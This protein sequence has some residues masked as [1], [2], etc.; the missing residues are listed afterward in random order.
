LAGRKNA[1]QHSASQGRHDVIKALELARL[2]GIAAT[3]DDG[4]LADN[5]DVRPFKNFDHS[6]R[7]A[8]NESVVAL[9][10]ASG[11]DGVKS[12]NVFRRVD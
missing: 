5:I 2:T 3:D 6:R 12:V 8:R 1:R 9:H 11:I 7:C 4:I 10:Q